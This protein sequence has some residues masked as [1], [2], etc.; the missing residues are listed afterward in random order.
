MNWFLYALL[1]TIQYGL[2]NFLYKAAAVYRCPSGLILNRAAITVSVLA[3]TALIATRSP[4]LNLPMMLFLAL[5]NSTFFA[6]GNLSKMKSL[7]YLPTSISLPVCKLNAVFVILISCI[8]LGDRPRPLQ[9]LGI[10]LSILL[11]YVATGGQKDGADQKYKGLGILFALGAASSTS[12]SIFTGK[13]AATNVPILNYM[14]ISYL[15]VACFTWLINQRDTLTAESPDM[16]RIN[17]YGLSIGIFNFSG[18]YALLKAYETGP[19]ALCQ[20]I[21]VNSFIIS[22]ILSMIV[23]KE[24]LTLRSLVLIILSICAVMLIKIK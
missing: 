12:I 16:S 9:W 4:F 6:L 18:H 7:K 24:K 22:I 23:F 15:F 11:L 20:G 2:I 10:L 13:V 17:K 19:L 5:V 1:A 21:F 14:V 8:V 3:M